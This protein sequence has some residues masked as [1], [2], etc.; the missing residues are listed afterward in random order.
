MRNIFKKCKNY[1]ILDIVLDGNEEIMN[2]KTRR[3]IVWV[4]LFLMLASFIAGV[5]I[6]LI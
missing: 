3:I 2:K 6:Y 1:G 4:M 5:I